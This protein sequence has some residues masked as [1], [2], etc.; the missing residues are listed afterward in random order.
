MLELSWASVSGSQPNRSTRL[1]SSSGGRLSNTSG[2]PSAAGLIITVT[3][4]KPLHPDVKNICTPVMSCTV[5]S[6]QLISGFMFSF[7]LQ[8]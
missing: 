7:G 6:H 5:Y 3:H 8:A 4:S 2:Q 1:D